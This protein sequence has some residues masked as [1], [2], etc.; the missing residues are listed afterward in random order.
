MSCN[1]P[2]TWDRFLAALN[3]INDNDTE[4]LEVEEGGELMF[5][6]RI[7]EDHLMGVTF[8]CELCHMRNLEDMDPE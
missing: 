3:L 8:Q 5:R 6:A 7:N 4:V 1:P 2:Q